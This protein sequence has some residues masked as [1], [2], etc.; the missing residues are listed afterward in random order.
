MLRSRPTGVNDFGVPRNLR[1]RF[2]LAFVVGVA[3][4][5]QSQG[6]IADLS[7]RRPRSQTCGQHRISKW[8]STVIR[9]DAVYSLGGKKRP[10]HPVFTT[11]TIWTR[12]FLP[13]ACFKNLIRVFYRVLR[14]PYWHS[15]D[16]F[17]TS[18]AFSLVLL[19]WHQFNQFKSGYDITLSTKFVIDLIRL[20]IT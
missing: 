12:R 3:E 19:I 2:V 15:V 5:D 20:F 11:R 8:I 7:A 13:I 16:E 9:G 6:T 4:R 1:I 10:K 14:T 18:I 17:G